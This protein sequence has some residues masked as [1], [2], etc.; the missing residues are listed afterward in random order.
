MYM[1]LLDTFSRSRGGGGRSKIK[2]R[3]R[4]LGALVLGFH[5]LVPIFILIIVRANAMRA[6][7]K[8]L[9]S[10]AAL[11]TSNYL[12]SGWRVKIVPWTLVTASKLTPRRRLKLAQAMVGAP[13]QT[14]GVGPGL[15]GRGHLRQGQL[16]QEEP[17]CRKQ[18]QGKAKTGRW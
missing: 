6:A 4:D 8:K 16:L 2:A 9:V 7:P 18:G 11:Y 17:R 5:C 13:A 3:K 1:N 10:T 12:F 15:P 14:G